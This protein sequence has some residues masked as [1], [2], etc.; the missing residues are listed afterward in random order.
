MK[1]NCIACCVYCFYVSIL[2]VMEVE[3]EAQKA[4]ETW[5]AYQV[6]ILIVMEVENEEKNEIVNE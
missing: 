3:N 6:S 1:Y 2:I 5:K 4:I